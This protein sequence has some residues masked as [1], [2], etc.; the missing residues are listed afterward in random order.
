M[1]KWIKAK[2]ISAFT[3]VPY[4]GNPAWVI[5]GADSMSDEEM[6][7][8]ACDLNPQSDTV[9]VLPETTREADINLRFFTG[10]GELNFSGHASVATYFALSDESVIPLTEPETTIRQRTKAG[11]QTVELRVKNKKVVRVTLTLSRPNYMDIETNQIQLSRI[12][13]IPAIELAAP[14]LPHEV[15]STG[16]N[17]LVVPVRSLEVMKNLN[18][19]YQLMDSFC[20]R[21]SLH[22]IITYCQETFEVG[23]TAFMR[24]FAP[25]LGVNEDPISGAAAGSLGCY[26]VRRKLIEP[27]NFTRIII[28]QGY[29]Q[30]RQGKVYVHIECTR[31][32]ILKVKFG[33]NAVLTFT[34]YM[35]T[36]S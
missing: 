22:G 17:D 32:Q 14:A 23:D 10:S 35:L 26:L 6:R 4:G 18:P 9:F 24:H 29:L 27:A 1:P 3:S 34:G 28:E 25:S 8:L 36:P 13:G 7:N 19:D 16:F 11:I 20:T 12:L 2:R 30:H 5:L 15:I 21:E 33:G 31:D